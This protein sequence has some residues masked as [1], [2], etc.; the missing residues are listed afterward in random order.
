M[1]RIFLAGASGI[2]GQRL[3]PLLARAGH[4]VTG[5]TRSPDRADRL[6][7]LGA[8]PRV[9][10][11]FDGAAL[12]RAVAEAAPEVLIHQ[13][14]DLP[15]RL[16][17]LDPEGLERAI[18][19]N[20]QIRTEGTRHL[21]A[22]AITAG[23][24]RL[25]AQ[26]ILW[27]Y[28]PGREPHVETDPVNTGATGLAAITVQ[29]TVALERGVLGAA[30]ESVVLRYGW[31]YGPGTGRDTSWKDPAVHVDAAA[32]AAFLAVARGSGLYNA[33]EPSPYA[34]SD[35]A[36]RELGWSPDFRL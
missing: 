3:L 28:A 31:L 35:R 20:A 24:R 27:I 30:M 26:S 10:D 25:I 15:D 19:G 13:L 23:A 12:H 22:A 8:T 5:T 7:E 11:A 17:S 16:F 2:I 6:R 14:T 36:R 4:V 1:A 32:H 29:G 21:V 33:A 34:S 9:V 18:R